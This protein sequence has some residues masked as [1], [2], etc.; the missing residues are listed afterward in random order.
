MGNLH[1]INFYILIREGIRF[2]QNVPPPP[3][4]FVKFPR[5]VTLLTRKNGFRECVCLS[6]DL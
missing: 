1:F 5:F 6:V 3:P 2:V 4:V